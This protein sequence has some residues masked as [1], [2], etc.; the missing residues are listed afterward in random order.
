MG[1]PLERR[2]SEG[3][4]V[5]DHRDALAMRGL[6]H[7]LGHEVTTLS[8]LVEAV[9]GDVSLPDESGYRL[10]LL[11]LELSRLQDI[12][13]HG[14]NGDMAGEAGPVDV[15]ELAAQLTDL[16]QAAYPADVRLLPGSAAVITISP[17]LLWRVLSNV[18]E[19]AARAAGRS[20]TV[21]V[22]IRQA[23]TTVI[24]VTDDGPGFGAGPPG[25]A[26]LGMQ[27][28]TSLLE[29]CGGA[30]AVEAPPQG[31]TTVLVALPAE[32]TAPARARAG[33]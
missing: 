25:R 11:A 17:V 4:R 33:R 21:T 1:S 29:A 27:V 31:G 13:R 22:A 32:I 12:I 7:D 3:R 19:N 28:V 14:L 30:L 16:A 2:R 10:E 18:V 26:S 24:D 20:G 5:S 6:L 8:Y 9:R 15:R 23:G